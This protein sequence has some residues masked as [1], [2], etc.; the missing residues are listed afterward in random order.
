MRTAL[1]VQPANG[2]DECPQT[3]PDPRDLDVKLT[4][5]WQDRDFGFSSIKAAVFALTFAPAIWM[6]HDLATGQYGP[7]P[8]GG[9]TYWSGVWAIAFL[10]LALTVTPAATILRWRQ[11]TIVRRMIG[12]TALAYTVAHIVIYFALRFWNFAFI[13]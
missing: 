9:L 7:V 2:T 6:L 3:Q 8:L 5:P 4:W 11:L 1:P 13:A 12:V 10:L